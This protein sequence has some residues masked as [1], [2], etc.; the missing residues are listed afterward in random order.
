MM[1]ISAD[2]DSILAIIKILKNEMILTGM[3]ETDECQHNR[4]QSKT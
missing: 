3:K 1:S 4:H 2:K